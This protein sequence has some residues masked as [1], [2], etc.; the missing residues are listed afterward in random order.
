ME[1]VL[2]FGRK[3]TI[4]S[5]YKTVPENLKSWVESAQAERR[6]VRTAACLIRN[7]ATTMNSSAE[8][9]ILNIV[10]S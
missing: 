10:P 2:Y 6:F 8:F 5:R 9:V 1:V 4:G 7:I 3:S